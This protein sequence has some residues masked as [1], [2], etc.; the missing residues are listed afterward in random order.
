MR[1]VSSAPAKRVA[2]V[3]VTSFDPFLVDS[4]ADTVA[5][6]DVRRQFR[7]A[8]DRTPTSAK[9]NSRDAVVV[10][11][12]DD[13][14]NNGDDDI[15]DG[16]SD[17]VDDELSSLEL[18]PSVTDVSLDTDRSVERNPD[19]NRSWPWHESVLATPTRFSPAPQPNQLSANDQRRTSPEPAKQPRSRQTSSLSTDISNDR[20]ND[21]QQTGTAGVTRK[22]NAAVPSNS[23]CNSRQ[24]MS[25]NSSITL[26]MTSDRSRHSGDQRQQQQRQSPKN[27]SPLRRNDL[28][29]PGATADF[30]IDRSASGSTLSVLSRLAFDNKVDYEVSLRLQ[31]ELMNLQTNIKK[32]VQ[33]K[34]SLQKELLQITDDLLERKREIKSTEKQM[35]ETMKKAE[36]GRS[37]LMLIEFKQESM[38]QELEQLASTISQRRLQL[39]KLES[40]GKKLEELGFTTEEVTRLISDCEELKE[41]I[42]ELEKCEREKNEFGQQLVAA[43]DMLAAERKENQ[44]KIASL[45]EDTEKELTSFRSQ[46]EIQTASF[47]ENAAAELNAVRHNLAEVTEHLTKSNEELSRTETLNSE[48]REQIQNLLSDLSRQSEMRDALIAENMKSLQIVTNEKEMALST[49][50]TQAAEE[51]RRELENLQKEKQ[52]T[53]RQLELQYNEQTTALQSQLATKDLELQAFRDRQLQHENWTKQLTERVKEEA[54]QKFQLLLVEERSKWDKEKEAETSLQ[55][56]SVRDEADRT[57]RQIREDL[58]HER[59]VVQSCHRQMDA[60]RA[61]LEEAR[62]LN[63]QSLRE[64]QQMANQIRESMEQEKEHQLMMLKEKMEQETQRAVE[65]LREAIRR[66]DDELERM[67]KERKELELRELENNRAIEKYEQTVL[68]EIQ[69]EHQRLAQS[70]NKSMKIVNLASHPWMSSGKLN[71][72][73]SP[74]RS[75]IASAMAGLRAAADETRQELLQLRQDAESQQQTTMKLERQHRAEIEELK[76]KLQKEK[77]EALESLKERLIKTRSGYTGFFDVVDKQKIKEYRKKQMDIERERLATAALRDFDNRHSR[78]SGSSLAK[79]SDRAAAAY[80]SPARVRRGPGSSSSLPQSIDDPTSRQMVAQLHEA[81]GRLE[82][83]NASLRRRAK[84]VSSEPDLMDA[85]RGD[86]EHGDEQQLLVQHEQQQRSSGDDVDG[87]KDHGRSR[88]SKKTDDLSS[89]TL[90]RRQLEMAVQRAENRARLAED[91]AS[92]NDRLLSQKLVETS[93]LQGAL[94]QQNKELMQLQR[95]YTQLQGRCT[96]PM[97]V[98]STR[99]SNAV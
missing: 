93:R 71:S 56:L 49:L 26:A 33:A 9:V 5:S 65:K 15:D 55:L 7:A 13:N 96:S 41:R 58:N 16:I 62:Q 20:R 75:S 11:D 18:E 79:S 35:K 87:R 88:P 46:M 73:Q 90:E 64:K 91:K 8:I 29:S 14:Y 76:E 74:L 70:L 23:V 54:Y 43:R 22:L 42:S 86:E 84:F 77:L 10:D 44:Q 81:V 17:D 47:R 19:L 69:Q 4:D 67:R 61:E 12:D 24:G 68:N 21:L 98:A 31:Q 95:A 27:G 32:S 85:L 2:C 80:S 72:S 99:P 28:Q 1:C 89:S 38:R 37:E 94:S 60:L 6:R 57:V 50:K 34:E 83:E 92:K 40:S 48:L 66:Q 36:D 39:Q 59:S 97:R 53:I 63:Q 3:P 82:A 30:S 25:E 78:D 51:R 52:Q 45:K